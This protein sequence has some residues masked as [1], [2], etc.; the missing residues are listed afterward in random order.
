MYMPPKNP[1]G[2]AV[3]QLVERVD[4][5]LKVNSSRLTVYVHVTG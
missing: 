2:N 3:A 4:L 1:Y 5:G